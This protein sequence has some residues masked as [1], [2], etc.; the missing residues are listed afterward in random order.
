MHGAVGAG[1]SQKKGG[2]M[3]VI[4]FD[5]SESKWF[6]MDG[7]GRLQLRI[8]TMADWKEIRKQ[9]V[10]KRVEF[11][12]VEGTAA[13]F[14]HEEINEDLQN[15]LFWDSAIVNFENFTNKGDPIPVTREN[16]VLMMT[17]NK[18]AKFFS[19]SFKTLSEDEARQ[20]E[21]SEKN[22]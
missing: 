17:S 7:G 4:N 22:S 15:E 10:K 20:A 3:T 6:E 21:V 9:T 11:K 1:L 5:E 8:P 18:F 19:E 16:K 13:R 12:K 14:E 2:F